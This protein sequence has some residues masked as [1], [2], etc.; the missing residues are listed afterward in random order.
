MTNSVVCMVGETS[1]GTRFVGIELD[2]CQ[3]QLLLVES[4]QLKLVKNQEQTC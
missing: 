4:K 2:D 3:G 1:N